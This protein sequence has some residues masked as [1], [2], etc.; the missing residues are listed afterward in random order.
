MVRRLVGYD[1]YSSKASIEV[2][3]RI[4]NLLRLYANFF[5]PV[6][7]LASKTRQGAKVPKACHVAQTPYPRLLTAGILAE[8]KREE[9]AAT[10]YRLNPVL[11][12]K[13]I[14]ENLENL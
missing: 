9:L 6:M 14:N 10:Y 12:L 4:Y 13:Q 3:N 5:Q 11:L 8:A 2:L 1:R 7:D